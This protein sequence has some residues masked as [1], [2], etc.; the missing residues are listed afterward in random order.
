MCD[1]VTGIA[2]ALRW[3]VALVGNIFTG[4]CSPRRGTTLSSTQED[5]APLRP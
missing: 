4:L 1:C 2:C 3:E 5:D